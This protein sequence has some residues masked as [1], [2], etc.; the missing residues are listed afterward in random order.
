MWYN[1]PM[2]REETHGGQTNE[3]EDLTDF[4][5]R[6]PATKEDKIAQVMEDQWKKIIKRRC[7]DFLD[8][9]DLEIFFGEKNGEKFDLVR[10][11]VTYDNKPTFLGESLR[12]SWEEFYGEKIS[13]FNGDKLDKT[14]SLMKELNSV[15]DCLLLPW[16]MDS[17]KKKNI[18]SDIPI[19]VNYSD[20][21]RPNR[22]GIFEHKRN[23]YFIKDSID[24][25]NKNYNLDEETVFKILNKDEEAI[26]NSLI[27]IDE[28]NK[29]GDKNLF[30]IVS[31][32]LDA[33][34]NIKENGLMSIK[35]S[36]DLAELLNKLGNKKVEEIIKYLE[37]TYEKQ[38]ERKE[39]LKM[40]VGLKLDLEMSEDR[41]DELKNDEVLQ[42][43]E[44]KMTIYEELCERK[45]EID[46][47]I[48]NIEISS[49]SRKMV[50]GKLTVTV[51]TIS[52]K[53]SEDYLVGNRRRLFF[54]KNEI[55]ETKENKK[56]KRLLDFD[57]KGIDNKVLS[58]L[59]KKKKRC[60]SDIKEAKTKLKESRF[61]S[62]KRTE[63]IQKLINNLNFKPEELEF[64]C[65]DQDKEPVHF[66]ETINQVIAK[67]KLKNR[68]NESEIKI[69]VEKNE[70]L[71]R[72]EELKNQINV[73]STLMRRH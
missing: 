42:N 19:D 7:N 70:L 40:V 9:G 28:E 39:N 53:F 43:S 62:R 18:F 64:L 32:A 14:I 45:K 23:S 37:K 30:T 26:K 44:N 27:I 46:E 69:M 2:N 15:K 72:V 65:L 68:L 52:H 21:V 49:I 58:I 35:I 61:E 20:T 63:M 54:L 56:S 50:D 67:R 73:L 16:E 22:K 57:G 51:K 48:L 55:K 25:L 71:K 24:K 34:K 6:V 5:A 1:L 33:I 38:N 10:K 11:K 47:A 3:H 29:K 31:K 17:I 60:E 12:R 41:L 66:N 8:N 59:N 13:S 36:N 4:Q